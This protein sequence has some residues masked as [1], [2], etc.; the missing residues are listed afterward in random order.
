[1]ASATPETLLLSAIINT[2]DVHQSKDY[3]ITPNN[4]IGYREVFE[5]IVAY[6]NNY[7]SCPTRSE[8]LSKFPAFPFDDAQYDMRYPA[9]EVKRKASARDLLLRITQA[10]NFLVKGQVE[11]AFDTIGDARLEVVSERP[12]NLLVD[13]GYLDAYDEVDAAR[14]PLSWNTAQGKTGGI[15][16][17]ELWYFAARQGHGKTS[18]LIDMAVSAAVQGLS[19]CI[20][21]LEMPKHQIQTRA[22]TAAAHRLGIEA[23]QF[24]M[25]HGQWDKLKYKRLLD[26]ISEQIPGEIVVHDVAMGRVTPATV[27]SRAGDHDLNI[28]DYVGL[29]YTDD[30]RPAISDYRAMA[31]ISNQLK[32]AALVKHSRVVGAAQINREGDTSSWRPPR[33]KFLAQ[34]D[35]LGND[36]DVVL[37]MKRYGRDACAVSLEKNRHGESGKI[38]FTRYYPNIG[39]FSEITRDDADEL[40]MNAEYEDD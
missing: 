7:R 6:E 34:S 10:S 29:M 35:H 5:W 22:H 25:L 4:L 39:D 16:A 26:Q 37:T 21:S 36:G 40:K 28:V 38:F 8:L 33:L 17:G 30:G 11:E 15:G 9:T 13:P 14:V 32:E 27:R 20:Y 1:M 12:Q 31:E 23:N 18:F 2:A 19:T 3:G 24:A